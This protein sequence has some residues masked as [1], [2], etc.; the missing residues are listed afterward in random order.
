MKKKCSYFKANGKFSSVYLYLIK[1]SLF[2]LTW[3]RVTFDYSKICRQR[4]FWHKPHIKH[5]FS[6]RWKKFMVCSIFL[7]EKCILICYFLF[8]ILFS[9][10]ANYFLYVT[11]F[12]NI[13]SLLSSQ[14]KKYSNKDVSK[15]TGNLLYHIASKT[16]PQI[17]SKIEILVQYVADGKIDTEIKLNGKYV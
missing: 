7:S 13:F 15:T 6:D 4:I 1:N 10:Y 16:K 9:Y 3:N 2:I 17:R 12:S 8:L 11:I 14:A 5:F